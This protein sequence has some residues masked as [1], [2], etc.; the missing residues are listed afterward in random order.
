[1]ERLSLSAKKKFGQN[2]LTDEKV[3][4]R[5][6]KGAGIS[7]TDTVL[8]IGPGFGTL[9]Q[10]LSE[11]AGHV[12]AVEIDKDLIP[13]L[14][15]TLTGYDNVTVINGDIME[16]DITELLHTPLPGGKTPENTCYKVAAN[17]PYYITTPVIMKILESGAP[18]ESI[19][20]MVQKEVGE[21]MQ[22]APGGKDYGVLSL[23]CQYYC[24]VKVIANVPSCS[25]IP[26]PGVDSVV[27][28]MK[29][30]SEPPVKVKDEQ[31][32]FELI[33]LGFSQRRK[34]LLNNLKTRY[35]KETAE[36]AI[37]EAGLPADIRGERLSLSDFALLSDILMSHE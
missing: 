34:T 24:D 14:S 28:N 30:H 26:R 10:A 33:R 36:L 37:K 25:F 15:E 35:G 13:V 27:V 7:E 31:Y 6:I 9:T 12:I 2:F 5:I 1:M 8:E 19:T 16:A 23:S 21:R 32:M 17:L 3:L 20:V 18:V 4:D 11:N 29:R 22:A